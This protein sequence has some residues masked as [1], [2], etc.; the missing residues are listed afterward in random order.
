M[1]LLE[2]IV[3]PAI[4]VD[5]SPPATP[6]RCQQAPINPVAKFNAPAAATTSVTPPAN[7]P[8]LPKKMPDKTYNSVD[9]YS[10]KKYMTKQEVEEDTCEDSGSGSG[11]ATSQRIVNKA[12]ATDSQ[13][14]VNKVQVSD[15][16]IPGE[17]PQD[18]TETLVDNVTAPPVE[19]DVSGTPDGGGIDAAVQA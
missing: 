12:P 5:T 13:S 18:P 4:S 2:R 6:S 1:I 9:N 11:S 15:Q 19:P 14:A 3:R 17:T 7:A 8:P 10:Y 16:S